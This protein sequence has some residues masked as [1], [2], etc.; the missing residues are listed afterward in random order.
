L[1]HIRNDHAALRV[2]NFYQVETGNDALFASLRMSPQESVLVIINL[3]SKAIDDYALQ[4]DKTALSGE[5]E[6]VPLL[7]SGKVASQTIRAQGSFENYQPVPEIP[8]YGRYILQLQPKT[9]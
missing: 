3:S 1:I 8:A 9:K 6:V 4:V 5:Y 7:Y 2:G